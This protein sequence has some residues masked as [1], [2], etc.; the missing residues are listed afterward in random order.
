MLCASRTT[1]LEDFK[2]SMLESIDDFT[3]SITRLREDNSPKVWLL[4]AK[5]VKVIDKQ[6]EFALT[7][8]S[9]RKAKSLG[10]CEGLFSTGT[11]ILRNEVGH[12]IFTHFPLFACAHGHKSRC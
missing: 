1:E 7:A 9:C 6:R 12:N 8:I 2:D 3:M 5:C 4:Q 11:T 10:D